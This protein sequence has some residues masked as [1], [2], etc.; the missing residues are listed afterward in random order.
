MFYLFSTICVNDR[1]KQLLIEGQPIVADDRIV[2]LLIALVRA[3]PEHCSKAQLLN[4]LW[5]D[6]VVSEWS[7]SKL[8]SETRQLFKQHGYELE[9]IQTLHGRG[10]RLQSELGEQLIIEDDKDHEQSVKSSSEKA[11]RPTSKIIIWCAIAFTF[12]M[13][14]LIVLLES[15]PPQITKSEKPSSIGRL[16][17]VDDN[18]E[19]NAL[20]KAYFESQNI[21]VYQVTSTDDALT[22]LALFQYNMVITDMGRDGEVLAGL[23]LL[24]SMRENNDNTPLILYTIV[25]SQAQQDILSEYQGQG[26][27]IE[28]EKLYELVLPYF[29]EGN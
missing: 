14:L 15:D 5:P 24:K 2:E 26:V 21:T 6:T 22:S 7:I 23:N 11:K 19:N 16:L 25:L 3:Y 17:W 27:A 9:I 10:Y 13:V 20:E 29:P 1:N 4:Q 12:F 8:V 18:P 28:A